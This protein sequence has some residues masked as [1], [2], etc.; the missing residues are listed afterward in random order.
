MSVRAVFVASAQTTASR[1]TD[2][3]GPIANHVPYARH[4][5][6]YLYYWRMGGYLFCIPVAFADIVHC[7]D[8]HTLFISACLIIITSSSCL[9]S[10]RGGTRTR[11]PTRHLLST[12][13]T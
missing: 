11:V 8:I 2:E 9:Y 13:R 1:S 5:A 7:I 4:D 6:V 12:I 3:G 10:M